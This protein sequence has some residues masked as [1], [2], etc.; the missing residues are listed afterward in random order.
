MK[1]VQGDKVKSLAPDCVGVILWSQD[2]IS[3]LTIIEPEAS[4]GLECKVDTNQLTLLEPSLISWNQGFKKEHIN[5]ENLKFK[6]KTLALD[7]DGEV[8][9]PKKR[10]SKKGKE[11]K[12][13]KPQTQE[14]LKKLFVKALMSG[15][16]PE[17]T[18]IMELLK[19]EKENVQPK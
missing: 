2:L 8:L 17:Q 12:A 18:R 11:D 19:K 13:V 1:L 6:Q 4:I 3:C 10:K 7:S 9:K 16:L 15:D 14:S 5:P